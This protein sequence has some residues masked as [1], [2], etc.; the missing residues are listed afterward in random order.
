MNREIIY[1]EIRSCT[2]S[3]KARIEKADIENCPENVM[4]I[5]GAVGQL[6]HVM[7]LLSVLHNIEEIPAHDPGPLP[8]RPCPIMPECGENLGGGCHQMAVCI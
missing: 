4:Y 6:D 2:G 7:A 1:A 8:L 5:R 3:A